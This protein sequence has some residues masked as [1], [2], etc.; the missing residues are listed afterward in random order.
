VPESTTRSR[1]AR[2]HRTPHT[3]A[4]PPHQ[5][6]RAAFCLANRRALST[7]IFAVVG[8]ERIVGLLVSCSLGWPYPRVVVVV[9]TVSQRPKS[10]WCPA[11]LCVVGFARACPVHH[12]SRCLFLITL[13]LLRW[14]ACEM[15]C[16]R[17]SRMVCGGGSPHPHTFTCRSQN[18]NLTRMQP[19]SDTHSFSLSLSLTT[20]PSHL[21]RSR[22]GVLPSLR[23]GSCTCRCCRWFTLGSWTTTHAGR[24]EMRA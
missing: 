20:T 8:C 21:S 12:C 17:N 6:L 2:V 5:L 10:V 13:A 11:L 9:V 7:V 24:S 18:E 16:R 15:D 19:S 14:L 4:H 3:S 22:L 23:A 1:S